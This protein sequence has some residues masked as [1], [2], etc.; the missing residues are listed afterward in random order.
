M[1]TEGA[2]FSFLTAPTAHLLVAALY[3][4]C[5]CSPDFL[6]LFVPPP[7]FNTDVALFGV[8]LGSK[9]AWGQGGKKSLQQSSLADVSDKTG[10]HLVGGT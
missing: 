4:D 6:F 8:L 5:L 9:A 2:S 7:I 3:F 1:G 10:G